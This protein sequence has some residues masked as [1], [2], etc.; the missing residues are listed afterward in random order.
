MTVVASVRR[1]DHDTF[2]VL[3]GRREH[4][5]SG[6]AALAAEGREPQDRHPKTLVPD[7][8]LAGDERGLVEAREGASRDIFQAGTQRWHWDFL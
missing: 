7:A 5:R 2:A 6:L 8:S 3:D 4:G 1:D